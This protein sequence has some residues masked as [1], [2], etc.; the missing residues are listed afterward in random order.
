MGWFKCKHA[1]E[2]TSCCYS[3]PIKDYKFKEDHW[4]NYT[5]ID[6]LEARS[7]IQNGL[8]TIEYQCIECGA[9]YTSKFPGKRVSINE[10]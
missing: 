8:T 1:W 5:I 7:I 4:Q 3:E 6:M 9:H 10:G 2:E